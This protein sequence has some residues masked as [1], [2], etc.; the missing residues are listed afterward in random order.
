[1]TRQLGAPEAAIHADIAEKRQE[2]IALCRRY[3]VARLEVFG[4]AAR[5]TDFDPTRSDADFLVEFRAGSTLSPLEQF[6][7]LTEALEELLGR[8]VDLV[9]PSALKNPFIRAAVNRSREIV[10]GS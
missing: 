7:G 1:M 5:G 6:F 10:Y 4:S 3:D 8:P 2:L 9:E